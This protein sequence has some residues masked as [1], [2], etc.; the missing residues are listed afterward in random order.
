MKYEYKEGE[1]A[2]K[3]FERAMK[4]IFKAPKGKQSCECFRGIFGKEKAE[5]RVRQ[6]LGLRWPRPCRRAV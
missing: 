5:I 2:S 3:N 6:G 1:Q 4:K